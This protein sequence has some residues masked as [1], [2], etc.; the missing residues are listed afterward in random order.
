MR[1]GR[2][3]TYTDYRRNLFDA[4]YFHQH[5]RYH[6]FKVEAHRFGSERSEDALTWNVFRQLQRAR[7]LHQIVQ[8]CTGIDDAEPHLYL[9]SLRIGNGQVEPWDLLVRARERFESDLPVNRPK[10]EPDIA[11]HLP[12]R[13]VILIEAKFC[14]ANALYQRDRITKL[15]DLTIDQLVTIY[16]DSKLTTLNYAEAARRDA[17]HAQLWRNTIFAE[18][19]AR[20]DS[21]ETEWFHINLV[22]K[23]HEADVCEPFLTLMHIDHRHRFEQVTWEQIHDLALNHPDLATL[24]RYMENKTEHLKLAFSL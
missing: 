20:Q 16:Q 22:R 8:L 19:I 7:C 15:A 10:T 3:W 23:G 17:L 2:T 24:C 12:G 13:Y 14:S 21:P 11:L 1:T 18:W 9:W 6:K 4:D 5:I